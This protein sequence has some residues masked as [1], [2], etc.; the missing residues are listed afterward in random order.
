MASLWHR[1]SSFVESN[2]AK[3]EHISVLE[4]WGDAH[5]THEVLEDIDQEEAK[6]QVISLCS[7]WSNAVGSK[8]R[9]ARSPWGICLLR[10]GLRFLFHNYSIHLSS[11]AHYVLEESWVGTSCVLLVSSIEGLAG[12]SRHSAK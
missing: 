10:Y 2:L 8:I 1:T 9:S 4:F 11:R 12:G 7:T 5:G 3:N 6:Q